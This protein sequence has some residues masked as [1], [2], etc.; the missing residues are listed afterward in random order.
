MREKWARWSAVVGAGAVALHE[1]YH[2]NKTAVD[3]VVPIGAVAAAVVVIAM[4]RSAPEIKKTKDA[5][6]TGDEG[7]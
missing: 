4:I 1:F 3:A 5:D 2:Q 7:S 6:N